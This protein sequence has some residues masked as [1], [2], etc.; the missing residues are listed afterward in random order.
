MA[1]EAGI[2]GVGTLA[3]SAD[4]SLCQY[5]FAKISGDGT[6]TVAAAATDKIIGVINNKPA[7]GEAI[8]LVMYG[9]QKVLLGGTVAAGDYLTSDANGNAVKA[10]TADATVYGQAVEAGVVTD[11][12]SAL[13]GSGTPGAVGAGAGGQGAVP[14]TVAT[15]I[16]D[17]T[18][19]QLKPGVPFI[20]DAYGG[21][22]SIVAGSVVANGVIVPAG[23]GIVTAPTL[24]I[25]SNAAKYLAAAGRYMFAGVSY[26]KAAVTAQVFTATH[27]VSATKFGSITIQVSNAGV[28]STKVPGATQTTAMAYTTLAAAQAARVAPTAGQIAVG[29]I[30]ISAGVADWTANSSDMTNGSGATTVAFVTT[31]ALTRISSAGATF[32]TGTNVAATLAAAPATVGGATDILALLYTTDGSGALTNGSV[33]PIWSRT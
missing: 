32:A 22:A 15:T 3:A 6:A 23:T 21:Y 26:E 12:I 33:T 25:D 20:V 11:I 7:S 10:T 9:K 28:Y 17:R 18:F 27:V 24:G 31:T 13:L 2:G 19:Y 14:L 16:V 8:D 5:C 4:L 29:Y 1:T 30:D